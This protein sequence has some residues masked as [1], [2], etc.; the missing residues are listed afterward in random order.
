MKPPGEGGLRSKGRL[1][2]SPEHETSLCTNRPS[3]SPEGE[4]SRN[5]VGV[6]EGAP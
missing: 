4:I 6:L 3:L 2:C 5:K 1:I